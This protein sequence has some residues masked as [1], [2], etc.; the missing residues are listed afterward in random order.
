VAAGAVVLAA[1]AEFAMGREPICTCGSVKLWHGVVLSAENSQ[2]LSDWYTPSHIVHGI[3]FFGLTWLVAR[4]TP[5]AWRFA[6]AVV[7]E[8]AWEVLENTPSIIDRYRAATISLDYYGD[9][10][11]NSMADIGAMMVGFALAASARWWVS[12]SAAVAMEAVV[13]FFIR[14]NLLLN[15]L[16]LIHPVEAIRKWQAGG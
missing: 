16:M 6:A 14:D 12:L 4:R 3:A 2:H 7:V 8:A 10:I 15:I 9:S 5:L 1:A 13:A 11:V